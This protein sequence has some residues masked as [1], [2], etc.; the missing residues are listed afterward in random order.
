M[1]MSRHARWRIPTLVVAVAAIALMAPPGAE[2]QRR[3]PPTAVEREEVRE[4]LRQR[5]GQIVQ[6]QLGL[7]RDEQAALV[8]VL[9]RSEE[10]R[11]ELGRRE[12]RLRTRLLG[13]E[14]LLA[15]RRG[16]PELLSDEEASE[17]LAEMAAI[18][19]AE[20]SLRAREEAALLEILTPAQVVRLYA[21]REQ[22]AERIRR[23]QRRGGPGAVAPGGGP[24]GPG[25]GAGQWLLPR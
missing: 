5:F 20:T 19:A 21:L 23:L 18:R 7:D 3:G 24:P 6:E 22:L 10:E 14:P 13:R 2:A 12:A 1:R 11:R 25:P 8:R 15:P 17:L 4:R 9:R 16:P